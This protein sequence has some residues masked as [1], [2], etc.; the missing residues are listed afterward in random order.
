[1]YAANIYVLP[2]SHAVS[3]LSLFDA[4]CVQCI[5][6]QSG[7][8]APRTRLYI[9]PRFDFIQLSGLCSSI[10]SHIFAVHANKY[11]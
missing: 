8:F 2:T 5:Y 9:S 1:M 4:M 11:T 6:Q 7:T 10:S 3:L